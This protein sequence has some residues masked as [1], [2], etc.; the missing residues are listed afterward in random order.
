MGVRVD[1]S[2]GIENRFPTRPGKCAYKCE[3]LLPKGRRRYCS[4]ECGWKCYV[5]HNIARGN[6]SVIRLEI[7]KRDKGVCARCKTDTVLEGTRAM[8]REWEKNHGQSVMFRVG[9][10]HTCEAHHK[11]AV[12]EG[13]GVSEEKDAK[14]D[15]F[16]TLCLECHRSE[17]RA[18]RHRLRHKFRQIDQ[19]PALPLLAT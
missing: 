6:P 2:Q 16:E 9:G 12:A 19:T 17:T 5:E 8:E 14:L 3:K 15:D 13:G 1:W 7:Y 10:K 18:L 4:D 11:V